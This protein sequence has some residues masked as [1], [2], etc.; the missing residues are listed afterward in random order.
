[1]PF[2]RNESF[3]G[4]EDQLQSLEQFLLRNTHQRLTICGLGGCGKSALALEFA[5][6]VLARQANYLIFWVPAISK[7]SFELAYREVGIHLRIPGITENNADIKRLVKE[8]LSSD[9]IRDWLMIVDN[10][11]DPRV[12]M[13]SSRGE[14]GSARLLDYLPYN[15]KGKIFFTTRSRKAA[16]ELTQSHVLELDD[17]SQAEGRHLLARQIA[18]PALLND[19]N[20]V[21]TLLESLAHLPLAVVQA[22]AFMNNN[23]ISVSSYISLLQEAGTETEL[24]S[25]HFEDSS[26]YRELES[27]IGKTWHISFDQIR[28]QDPLAAEYLSF[29]ACIDRISVP[30]S[31]LPPGGSALQ[32]IKA[33]GTLKG[34]AFITE[35]QQATQELG[36]ERFFDMHRLV[37]MASKWWLEG[38]DEQTAWTAKVAMRL[39]ELVPYGGHANREVW[40]AYVPHAIYL[41]QSDSRLDEIVRASLLYRVGLCQSSLGQYSAS[42]VS[43]RQGLRLRERIFGKDH[44]ETF[45]TLHELG[46]ALQD[47]GKYE[48]A[49]AINRQTLALREKCFGLEH[50]DTLTSI[51][52]LAEVLWHEAKYDAA[53]EM[54]RKALWGRQKILGREHTNTLDSM[55][56]F[57]MVLNSQAKY[58]EAESMN[59]QA[60]ATRKK[61]LGLKDPGTLRSMNNLAVILDGQGKYSETE[62]I[63]RQTLEMREN[64]HGL[65]HPDTLTSMNNLAV[66]LGRQGK[67]EAAEVM[68]RQILATRKKVLGLEHP[69]TL[70]SINNLAEM[71]VKQ[72]K[73][74]AAEAMHRQTLVIRKK[75][76]G[77]KHPYTLAS[78]HNLAVV[79]AREGK[80]EEAE[81]MYRET[82]AAKEKVLGL[83]HPLTLTSVYG[84]ASFLANR[85]RYNESTVLYERACAGYSIALGEDH[86]T[87][88]ECRKS[89]SAMFAMRGEG[90]PIGP[91]ETR[92][93]A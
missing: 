32:Q 8:A 33:V 77:L 11:D 86:P 43:H 20:A 56:T 13:D 18:K 5:Y 82:L 76:L 19:E 26:R 85:H 92:P 87:T 57:A 15:N 29:M 90:R 91:P 48:A 59:R 58:D 7:E 45:E 78:M 4:R 51:N 81:A 36:S 64:I 89:F 34:Y 12:L 69:D 25:E 72:S 3:V 65:K 70:I 62:S 49:E 80:D 21:H 60:L 17:M 74:E 35:R 88:R 41:A 46:I 52:S 66:A 67:Y 16:G 53:E 84:F 14:P 63:Y 31:L 54:I 22:A 30:R 38:H 37:H 44:N 6:R 42:E 39:E 2:P 1:L 61:V 23:D 50:P 68:N 83:E 27:T 79:L 93:V 24:F 55:E 40:T 9:I 73:Y 75:V 47:G 71:L 10:A 28:R